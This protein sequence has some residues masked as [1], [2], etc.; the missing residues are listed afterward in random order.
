MEE[1]HKREQYFFDKSTAKKIVDFIKQYKNPCLLCAPTIGIE[2]DSLGLKYSLLD[3]DERFSNLQGFR[4]YDMTRP[5]WI[6]NQFGI[7]F[8]DPPFFTVSLSKLYHAI[9]MLSHYKF[10]QPLMISYLTRRA[11]KFLTSFSSFNVTSTGFKPNYITVEK[12]KKNDI[13]FF[14][15]ISKK[16]LALLKL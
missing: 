9:R 14:G 5:E 10:T 12:S 4:F 3:I 2:L 6:E 1:N 11:K 7:I 16:N 8:C 15:N 13:E